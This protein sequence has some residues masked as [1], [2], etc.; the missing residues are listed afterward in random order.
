MM[1]VIIYIQFN[2]KWVIVIHAGHG[3]C[4]TDSDAQLFFSRRS[5]NLFMETNIQP[6]DHEIHQNEIRVKCKEKFYGSHKVVA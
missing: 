4:K 2:K 6:T 5:Q 1:D 3:K